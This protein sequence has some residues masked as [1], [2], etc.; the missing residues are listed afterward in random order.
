MKMPVGAPQQTQKEMHMNW[1]L[2]AEDL[3]AV[4]ILLILTLAVAAYLQFIIISGLNNAD[5]IGQWAILP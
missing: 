4:L 2:K 5:E 3:L 1:G